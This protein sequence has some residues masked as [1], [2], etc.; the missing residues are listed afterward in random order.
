MTATYLVGYHG[1]RMTLTELKQWDR[2]RLVDPEMQRR[3]IALMD[4]GR[5]AGHDIGVGGGFRYSAEQTAL[6]KDRHDRAITGCCFYA[7]TYWRKKPGVAHAAPPGRSFHETTTPGGSCLA[8]DMVGWQDGWM[9][10]NLARFGLREFSTVNKEPWHVQCVEVPNSRSQ[11]RPVQ[12]ALK[13]F[14]LPGIGNPYGTW[15]TVTKPTITTG[16]KGDAVSYLQRVL[17]EKAGQH[18]ALD[19]MFGPGTATA[20]R[21]VQAWCRLTVDGVV[22]PK[23]WA[24]IDQLAVG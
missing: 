17:A 24:E 10:R 15:P 16:A 22:G 1:R 8:V 7:G 6:F 18:V 5:A 4:A 13:P 14:P 9:G 20:V 3:L 2:F 23:T 19:G 11:Y 12:H 21:N